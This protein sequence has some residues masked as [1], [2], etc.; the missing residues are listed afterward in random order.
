MD[1]RRSGF[2]RSGRVRDFR[3][4][5]K[6]PM[7]EAS[8]S[9]ACARRRPAPYIAYFSTTDF[10]AASPASK[11]LPTILSMSMNRHMT[12]ER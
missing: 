12:F 2:L 4:G 1:Q 11:S 3:G 9:Q 5:G 6:L 10:S 8:A 7:R